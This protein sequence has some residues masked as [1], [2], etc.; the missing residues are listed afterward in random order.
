MNGIPIHEEVAKSVLYIFQTISRPDKD[1]KDV[2]I[3][4]G[5][6][7]SA[8]LARQAVLRKQVKAFVDVKLVGNKLVS[9][10]CVPDTR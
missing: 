8:Y 6:I 2:V 4:F 9:T 10:A 7:I 3:E 1:G 5:D